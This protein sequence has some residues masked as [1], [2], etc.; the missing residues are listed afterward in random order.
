[1]ICLWHQWHY[2]IIYLLLTFELITD[3]FCLVSAVS[4]RWGQTERIDDVQ[5]QWNRS[6]RIKGTRMTR[7]SSAVTLD[8]CL[9]LFCLLVFDICYQYRLKKLIVKWCHTF[10]LGEAIQGCY[11]MNYYTPR[12]PTLPP[13]EFRLR[14]IKRPKKQEGTQV[15]LPM[16]AGCV[17]HNDNTN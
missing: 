7:F 3:D 15:A 14:N 11:G 16:N 2:C 17:V 8:F 13:W 6:L 12:E 5:I 4:E 1:M 10:V 9:F